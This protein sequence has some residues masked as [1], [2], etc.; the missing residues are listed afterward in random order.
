M[1]MAAVVDM[2]C[3][4]R[5][6]LLL[7]TFEHL[8]PQQLSD[9][10]VAGSR[11]GRHRADGRRGAGATKGGRAVLL[12][13]PGQQRDGVLRLHARVKLQQLL[14]AGQRAARVTGQAGTIKAAI[15]ARGRG[16][17]A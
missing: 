3:V 7:G 8:S 14:V 11:W 1:H 9:L 2:A 16:P 5:S 12:G 6:T 4:I 15:R 17:T 10:A 13:G